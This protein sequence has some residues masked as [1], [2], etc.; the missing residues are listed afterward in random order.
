V[1]GERLIIKILCA[2]AFGVAVIMTALNLYPSWSQYARSLEEPLLLLTLSS[3]ASMFL[4]RSFTHHD[5]DKLLKQLIWDIRVEHAN[6]Y[7]GFMF[8]GVIATPVTHPA[9]WIET[10]HMVFT[11]LAIAWAYVDIAYYY[12]TKVGKFL[13]FIAVC[14]AVIGMLGGLW[15]NFWTV[16]A[17][18]LIAATPI[19]FH[20]L[21]TNHEAL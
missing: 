4:I 13:G 14:T 11:F 5:K 17:G 9:W 19:M 7:A 2:L 1:K 15:L 20:I 18:E 12:K 10:L 21:N 6:R 3:I 16:G 8:L